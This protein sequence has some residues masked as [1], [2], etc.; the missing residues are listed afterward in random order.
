[1]FKITD[2]IGSSTKPFTPNWPVFNPLSSEHSKDDDEAVV[3]NQVPHKNQR[4]VW[5]TTQNNAF[6]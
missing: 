6:F 4:Y 1:M 2:T 5:M 3:Q